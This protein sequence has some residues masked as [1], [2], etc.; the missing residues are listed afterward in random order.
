MSAI[1]RLSID[2]IEMIHEALASWQ[3][4][5]DAVKG[6]PPDE[7]FCE[8]VRAEQAAKMADGWFSVCSGCG[9]RLPLGQWTAPHAVNGVRSYPLCRT[10]AIKANNEG[11]KQHVQSTSIKD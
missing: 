9:A 6:S 4:M 10:C 5:R 2:E 11:E 1:V 7:L 3:K 8:V